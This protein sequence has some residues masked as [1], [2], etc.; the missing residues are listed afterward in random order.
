[1]ERLHLA[2]KNVF[3]TIKLQRTFSKNLE[4]KTFIGWFDQ[5][6]VTVPLNLNSH[7]IHGFYFKFDIYEQCYDPIFSLTSPSHRV[8]S[9]IH[10]I[11]LIYKMY[12][13]PKRTENKCY[14]CV[15]SYV[16]K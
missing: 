5:W 11:K 4:R 2:L 1:M 8:T 15:S 7:I 14:V 9:C 3:A 12:I 13:P 10:F 6:G 16:F